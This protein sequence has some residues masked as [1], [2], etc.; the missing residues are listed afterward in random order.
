MFPYSLVFNRLESLRPKLPFRFIPHNQ[1]NPV[2]LREVF[3]RPGNGVGLYAP[4]DFSGREKPILLWLGNPDLPS[5]PSPIPGNDERNDACGDDT[6]DDSLDQRHSSPAYYFE[7][8]VLSLLA[9]RAW[10]GPCG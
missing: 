8:I 6:S 7:S 9:S 1:P 10:Q 4:A 5:E 3:Q 2:P